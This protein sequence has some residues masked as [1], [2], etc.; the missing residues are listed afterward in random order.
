M[1]H[2]WQFFRAGGLDQVRL[3]TGADVAHLDELDPKLW[4][5]LACPVKGLEFDEPTLQ[6]LDT[7]KDG[8]IRV[9]EILEAVRFCR[10]AL[11]SLDGLVRGE[12]R[13]PLAQ[14]RD[15]TA[16]GRKILGSARQILQALGQPAATEIALADT[17]DT[18][19]IFAKTRFNGDG[20][21]TPSSAEDPALAQ[22]IT[23]AV[24]VVG[25][26][27]DRNGETGISQARLDVFSAELAAYAAWW[28]RR[29]EPGVL[30]LGAATDAAA[31][32]FAPVRAKIDDWFTRGRI[33]A[34]DPRA[35]EPLDRVESEL[36]ALAARDLSADAAEVAGLPLAPVSPGEPLPLA[37]RINPAWTARLAAFRSAVVGPILGAD[38][39]A[40][41]ADDWARVQ[42]T[43]A[44]H[45]AWLADKPA[46]KADAL[47]QP[48]I[49]EILA[50]GALARLAELVARDTGFSAD[51]DGIAEVGKLL[52]YHRHLFRLLHNFTSFTD[53]YAP[54]QKAVF[55]AGTLFLDSRAC[56]LCVRVADP[57]KH[58]AMAA[59]SK[60]YLAYCNCTR[61]GGEAMQIAAVF[62]AGDSDFLMVGRNGIFFD[63]AGKDWDATITKVVE[64]SISLREAFWAPYKKFL[65]FVEDQIN[66]RAAAADTASTQRL[67]G[68]AGG[69]PAP[70]AT[71]GTFDLSTI[72][73]IGVAVSGAAA[74]VGGILE[75][76]F[77]LGIWMPVGLLGLILAISGPSMLIAGLKLRQRNLG[78]ILDANGWAV[79]GRV[80]VNIPFGG[81]LTQMPEF[82]P[83]SERLSVDPYQP[84]QSIWVPIAR[85]AIVL[86]LLCASGVFAYHQ[87]W[88]PMMAEE[89]L[90][91]LGVPRYLEREKTTAQGSVDEQQKVVASAQEQV[92]AARAALDAR[93]A[94]GAPPDAKLARAQ[95]RL[96]RAEAKL[97]RAEDK[98]DQYELRL[99]Q[100]T[101][102]LDVA[103]DADEARI[104]AAEAALHPVAPPP[105]P[106]PPPPPVPPTP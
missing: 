103:I 7:D 22:V 17:A 36:T 15:D 89:R 98:L 100:A 3:E 34:F 90:R 96:D 83:G 20:V 47:G 80:A 66:K 73:L 35:T 44:P 65:R 63:R 42:A 57:A 33:T 13:I 94:T 28:E 91:L 12:D 8:R 2:R 6:W 23:D 64:N 71:G 99:E 51:F 26:E 39:A 59:L 77:G 24:A 54:G 86:A 84:R 67:A 29:S 88:L 76:F 19:A 74:V 101:E 104:A 18:A 105:P 68:A 5:A 106:P 55:Q 10:E 50:S 75:A 31:A 92:T 85:A 48:R 16:G 70:A 32:A 97:A 82:P 14:L 69:A 11:K 25:G 52:L 21:V 4:V 79:N 78:P 46:T 38:H 61:P 27:P 40:I 45:L 93:I 95:A 9:P 53:F 1:A 43:L 102:A 49:A 62:S 56:E 81:L 30:S 41:S 60:C 58:A 72:A 87:G 37:T